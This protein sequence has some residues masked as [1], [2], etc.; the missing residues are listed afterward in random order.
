MWSAI[1]GA[2]SSKLAGMEIGAAEVVRLLTGASLA[3][4]LF[5]VGLRL[6]VP[7]VLG[8]LRA[9]R[10]LPILA[11]NFVLVPLLGLALA[12]LF[13][14]PDAQAAGLLLLA[15]APF[16][17]VVPIFARFARADL[18]LA[19]GLTGLFPFASAF[20]TPLACALSLKLLGGS[21]ALEPRFLAILG[22]LMA[23]ITAP[24]L[25]GMAMRRA[26]P[27]IGA[28]LLRPLEV[29]TEALGALSL[30][31]VTWVELPAILASG[32]RALLAT[33]LF[34]ELALLLG[35]RLGGAQL[36]ARRVIAL[37]TSNRN[38]ALAILLA[39]DG[40]PDS[41]VL[42]AVVSSGLLLILLG[43]AHVGWWRFAR[44][45]I[46]GAGSE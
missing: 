38:I 40:F 13:E 30:A 39:L 18:A 45:R 8:A 11:A 12:R 26:S 28:R 43:L 21:G 14:L 9:L 25:G 31:Y 29:L 6:S 33:A 2:D 23:T 35:H 34:F 5:A 20:L 3:G 24:V 44:R 36:G 10:I 19:A 46:D 42:G 1:R 4:L 16:A 41:P 37:G 22:V 32:W 17:P 15:A 7:E 27:A